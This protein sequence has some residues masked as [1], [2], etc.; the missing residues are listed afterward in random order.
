[1]SKVL[2]VDESLSS[3]RNIRK[4]LEV[5][6][7]IIGEAENASYVLAMKDIEIPDV[8]VMDISNPKI[9]SIPILKKLLKKFPKTKIYVITREETEELAQ[10][11]LIHGAYQYFLI[12]YSKEYFVR[13]IDENC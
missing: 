7:S 2:I 11:A 1:M 13:I 6:H 8:I 4:A 12:P 5:K 9:Y 10:F 3:R